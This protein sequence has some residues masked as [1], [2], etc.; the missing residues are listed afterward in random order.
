MAIQTLTAIPA[1]NR[2]ELQGNTQPPLIESPAA[3]SKTFCQSL[4]QSRSKLALAQSTAVQTNTMAKDDQGRYAN[5]TNVETP[6]IQS[7]VS[8]LFSL[9][10]DVLYPFQTSPSDLA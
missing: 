2:N 4:H 7:S 10:D 1:S 8:T 3:S 5:A 6:T 9:R